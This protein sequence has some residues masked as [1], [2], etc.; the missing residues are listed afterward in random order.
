MHDNLSSV[1]DKNLLSKSQYKHE[2]F[3][4]LEFSITPIFQEK[5]PSLYFAIKNYANL[6][7]NVRSL[8]VFD[9]LG[10]QISASS[11]LQLLNNHECQEPTLLKA[12]I[13]CCLKSYPRIM[14]T[15]CNLPQSI[16]FQKQSKSEGP[17]EIKSPEKQIHL[18]L[19]FYSCKEANW[20][21]WHEQRRT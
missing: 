18:S 4:N 6:I 7:C 8:F 16:S 17:W 1:S 19:M 14:S 5:Y 12:T 20:N 10:I 9:P 13:K 11:D 2:P 3:L 15:S 21:I